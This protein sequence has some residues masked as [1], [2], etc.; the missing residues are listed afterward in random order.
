MP[1]RRSSSDSRVAFSSSQRSRARVRAR[2]CSGS[3]W[4]YISPASIFSRS[5]ATSPITNRQSPIHFADRRSPIADALRPP[6]LL[7][8][9]PLRRERL[10]R[11]RA[12]LGAFGDDRADD[13]PIEI[14]AQGG[15]LV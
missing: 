10:R 12:G 5:D 2:T 9:L 6:L 7:E 15:A 8:L 4:S 1:R 3:C 11:L 14:G 13:Q